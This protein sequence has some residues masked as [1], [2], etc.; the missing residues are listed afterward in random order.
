MAQTKE[1]KRGKGKG[2]QHKGGWLTAEQCD[3]HTLYEKSVQEPE[4]ECDLIEQVWREQ[5]DRACRSIREDFCGTAAVCIE[6]LRR[7]DDHTAIGV[8]LDEGV[9][10]WSRKRIPRRL[11]PEQRERLNLIRD[12]V[13]TVETERVDSVLAMNFSYYLFKKRDD[14]LAYFKR[15]H[16]A[17]VDDGL[18]LLDAYGGSESFTELEEDRD[19]DGFTYVWDQHSYNPITGE[20]VNFIH[21]TFP[22]GTEIRNAFEYHWRLWTLPEIQELL[23]EAGFSDAKVYWEG[24]DENDEGNGEWTVSTRGEACPGWIAYIVGIK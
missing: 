21:F 15:A 9:L 19:L 8:D 12:N 16:A 7:R 13:M 11:K 4:A 20:A 1:K 6:W 5:R 2:K 17:L 22:D 24:T 18:F 23:I 14:L 10:A 3:R